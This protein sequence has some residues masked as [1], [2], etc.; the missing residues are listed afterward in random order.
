MGHS[1]E[2]DV[3]F[4]PRP[5]WGFGYNLVVPARGR[6]RMQRGFE[7]E[8]AAREAVEAALVELDC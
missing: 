8:A 1:D 5:W 3:W 4:D 7:T 2:L 6:A